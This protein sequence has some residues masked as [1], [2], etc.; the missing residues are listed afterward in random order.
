[1]VSLIGFRKIYFIIKIQ[2]T[3]YIIKKFPKKIVQL[4]ILQYNTGK[5]MVHMP[6]LEIWEWSLKIFCGMPTLTTHVD[7]LLYSHNTTNKHRAANLAH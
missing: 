5:Q 2:F 1:M 3:I 4:I 7:H 6:S